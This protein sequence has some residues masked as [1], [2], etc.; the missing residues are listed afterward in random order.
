MGTTTTRTQFIWYAQP[1]GGR[2]LSTFAPTP[3]RVLTRLTAQHWPTPSTRL[4]RTP[5]HSESRESRFFAGHT[6]NV[7][8]TT[9]GVLGRER[10]WELTIQMIG[11]RRL[12]PP[13]KTLQPTPVGVSMSAI[14]DHVT[15]PAWL[16]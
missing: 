1:I 12:M 10:L 16:S 15:A 4:A 6:F 7:R 5:L 8:T 2:Q 9:V 14:A 3:R 13:N 11:G